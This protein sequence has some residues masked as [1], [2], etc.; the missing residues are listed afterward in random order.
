LKENLKRDDLIA[1]IDETRTSFDTDNPVVPFI[2]GD[3]IGI[4]I[5]PASQKVFDSAVKKAYSDQR[6]IEWTEVLAGQKAFDVTDEWLPNK[7]L[8]LFDNYGIGIKG[9]LTTPVGG[10]IR[11]INVAIRQKLDLYAC[12]RP[13]RWFSGIESPTKNPGDVDIALFRENTEDVYSGKELEMNSDEVKSLNAFLNSEFGWEIREDSGIGIKPISKTASERL[14]RAAL[15]YAVE[16]NKKNLAIVHKGNIMK[17]TEG[18]FRAWGYELVKSEFSDVA[19]SWDDC[20]GDPGDKILVQDVIADAFLQQILIKPQEFDII[21]TTNLNGDYASDALAAQIGGIGISPGGNINYENG[22]SVFE[23]THGTA[24]KHAGKDKANP[25]SLI[26]SGEM[27]FRYMGWN[28]A[29]DLIVKSMEKSISEGNVTY[30][31]ARGRT[32]ATTLSSSDFAKSLTEN[33]EGF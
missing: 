7:T 9:P 23:A 5:W 33:I 12:L 11:S 24:P 22:K 30:D 20:N 15:N 1:A 2:E 28:E 18:A 10:G 17:F 13:L 29:A 25:G 32:D 19:V 3:G 27:M 8:E 26:L 6:K 4:D 21:A 31:L 16:N 14:I